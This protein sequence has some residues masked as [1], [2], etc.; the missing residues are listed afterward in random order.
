MI[1]DNAH[2]SPPDLPQEF[3]PGKKQK[4]FMIGLGVLMALMIVTTDISDARLG[5]KVEFM[6]M[7]AISVGLTFYGLFFAAVKSI[8]IDSSTVTFKHRGQVQNSRPLSDF[9]L[10]VSIFQPRAGKH[11]MYQLQ[12]VERSTPTRTDNAIMVHVPF[13]T[14]ENL[15]TFVEALQE[16]ISQPLELHFKNGKVQKDYETGVYRA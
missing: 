1:K 13:H 2:V 6:A 3:T 11:Y 15:K 16:Q 7:C 4:K 9:A 14:P 10:L 12:L 5:E 8:V